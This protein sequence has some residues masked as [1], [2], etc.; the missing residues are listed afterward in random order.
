MDRSSFLQGQSQDSSGRLA[1]WIS[2]VM[3]SPTSQVASTDELQETEHEVALL[4]SNEYHPH[5]Y[6]QLPDFI[7]ELLTRGTEATVLYAPLLYH[8]AGCRSC[9]TAYVELYDA[10]RYALGSVPARQQLGQGTRT[11]AATPSRMLAHLCQSLIT[12]AE[13]LLKQARHEHRDQDEAARSL[14]QLALQVSAHIT[15]ST[16]RRQALQNLVPVANLFKGPDAPGSIPPAIQTYTPGLVGTGVR[17][18][19][20]TRLNETLSRSSQNEQPVIHLQARQLEATIQQQGEQLELHIQGLA[21]EVHGQRLEI[22]LPLGGITELV[23]WQGGDPRAIRSASSVD[24]T[25]ALVMPLGTTTLQLSRP[26]ER[27]L[28]EGL[29]SQVEVRAIA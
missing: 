25:G 17:R 14:L 8:L 24:A 16:V 23:H 19:T 10:L 1:Q 5:F 11:L 20:G 26:E 13:A 22:S 2:H 28:L 27:N 6:Q 21:E 9:H 29:F 15:Q 12:Q 7:K 18:G 3:Q 4:L